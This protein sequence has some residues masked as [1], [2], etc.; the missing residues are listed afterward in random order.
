M[1]PGPARAYEQA[2]DPAVRR[3]AGVFYTPPALIERVLDLVLEPMLDGADPLALR[4][5]D[6]SC[7]GGLFLAAAAERIASR[8]RVPVERAHG[9]LIGID[10]DA[11]A[12]ALARDLVPGADLRLGNGLLEDV[13]PV[14]VVVGNPPFLSQ[15]RRATTMSRAEV[16]KIREV[17]GGV[18]TAYTDVSALFLARS[19]QQVR[20]GGRIGLVQPLSVLATRDAAGVREY[21]ET[22][23]RLLDLWASPEP[24]FPDASVLTCVV[25]AVRSSTPSSTPPSSLPPS[26]G[27]RA[28]PAFGIP[29]VVLAGDHGVL[30]D[31]GSVTA[32]FRD[33]YY[34]LRDHL[35]DGGPG[36]PLITSGLI[37]P[38]RC[39]WG[40]RHA[41]VFKRRWERPTVRADVLGGPLGEW[42]RKRLVPKVLIGTQG[43]VIEA[44]VDVSGTW[45]PGVPVITMNTDRRWHALAVLLAPPVVAHAAATY[46]GTAL[47]TRAIKLSAR[48]LAGLPLPA[49]TRIWDR[50]AGL[51]ESA[52]PVPDARTLRA[53]A[54]LM[55]A[56]YDADASLLDWWL[57][58]ARL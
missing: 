7:G 48:Q 43:R 3:S 19:M 29:E 33:Q 1:L 13:G 28:A 14:N 34:G 24:Q 18:A 55:C 50:A 23:G 51:L 58:R 57:E 39:E 36:F 53:V 35:R 25:T 56:A 20:P 46:L 2:L 4:V 31:L 47:S 21:V 26:W 5:L 10:I 17:L 9:C 44:V 40:A 6:P 27:P 15:L 32:D 45:L 38:G 11:A 54:R 12:I 8:A 22:R 42:A 49:R 41:R 52:A 16:A 30:G 37:E